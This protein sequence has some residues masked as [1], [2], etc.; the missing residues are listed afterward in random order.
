[1][2]PSDLGMAK[3]E[4]SAKENDAPGLSHLL[5]PHRA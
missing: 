5:D 3:S 2:I 1:M 4:A